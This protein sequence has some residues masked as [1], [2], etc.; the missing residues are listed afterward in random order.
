MVLRRPRFNNLEPIRSAGAP[1]CRAGPYRGCGTTGAG[2]RTTRERSHGSLRSR[3]RKPA[4]SPPGEPTVAPTPGAGGV[5]R[6]AAP[7]ARTGSGEG[8]TWRPRL[9]PRARRQAWRSPSLVSC[10][11][12]STV[13]VALQPEGWSERA[14]EGRAPWCWFYPQASTWPPSRPRARQAPCWVPWPSAWTTTSWCPSPLP[15]VWSSPLFWC[16]G[17]SDPTAIRFFRLAKWRSRQNDHA[18]HT[19]GN[20]A[21]L[22]PYRMVAS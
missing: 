21:L 11:T 4:T 10:L 17:G 13:G 16:V 19:N 1:P 12:T 9:A 15:R 6:D 8:G 2:S 18:V 7:A 14:G 22:P 20:K 3:R 5:R